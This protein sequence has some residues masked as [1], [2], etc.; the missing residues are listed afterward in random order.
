MP[1]K[2]LVKFFLFND[3]LKHK[4]INK[5]A[6]R[7]PSTIPLELWAFQLLWFFIEAFRISWFIWQSIFNHFKILLIWFFNYFFCKSNVKN[8]FSLIRVLNSKK[9]KLKLTSFYCLDQETWLADSWKHIYINQ[10]R[11]YKFFHVGKFKNV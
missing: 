2:F 7:T 10:S 9:R 1:L 5:I 4:T 3:H 8:Y 11:F 6:C